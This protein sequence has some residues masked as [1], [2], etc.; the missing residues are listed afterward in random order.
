MKRLLLVLPLL[1]SGTVWSGSAWS[2][3]LTVKQPP[4][5]YPPSAFSTQPCVVGTSA[6][7]SGVIGG[8]A[9]GSGFVDENCQILQTAALLGRFNPQAAVA[10][11]CMQIPEVESAYTKL[12]ITCYQTKQVSQAQLAAQNQ[13]D[14]QQKAAALLALFEKMDTAK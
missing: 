10:Y 3:T 12:G 1:L 8:L 6:G 7:I 2:E 13:S 4:N 5:V 14:D 11:L 9:V